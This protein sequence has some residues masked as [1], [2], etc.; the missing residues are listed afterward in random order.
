QPTPPPASQP[1]APPASPPT[2]PPAS[3][4]LNPLK[5]DFSNVSATINTLK[6][7]QIPL[8]IAFGTESAPLAREITTGLNTFDGFEVALF[9]EIIRRWSASTS[10]NLKVN[11]MG[12]KIQERHTSLISKTSDIVAAAVPQ[13]LGNC[14]SGPTICNS[15]TYASDELAILTS[16]T[17]T[18]ILPPTTGAGTVEEQICKFLEKNSDAKI[19]A[20]TNTA[21][22]AEAR[23]IF[24]KCANLINETKDYTDRRAAIDAVYQGH[25]IGYITYSK[26]L[27]YYK[28]SGQ[29]VTPFSRT[30]AGSPVFPLEVNAMLR[31]D[32]KGLS[33][34][35]D[36]TLAAI[37]LDKTYDNI[38]SATEAQ[39]KLNLRKQIQIT[40]KDPLCAAVA[41]YWDIVKDPSNPSAPIPSCA[42]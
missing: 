24:S 9:N 28:L 37:I 18:S 32:S 36:I 12:V 7:N 42:P 33:D 14:V 38:A 29:K 20:L 10:L 41:T 34:L 22:R 13:S 19:A 16:I 5:K 30:S 8:I 15:L 17:R 2:A 21:G 35:I 6:N 4:L 27:E 25:T 3:P 23:N 40:K 31:Q 26:I 11:Q 39:F 1:A